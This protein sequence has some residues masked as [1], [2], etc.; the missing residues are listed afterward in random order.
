MTIT[1]SEA[2]TALVTFGGALFG[3]L[4]SAG[5]ALSQVAFEHGAIAGA[6]AALSVLGY[7][8]YTGAAASATPA[9]KA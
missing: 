8:A 3:Y 5:F 6:V 7:S 1:L 9:V 2:E 4:A